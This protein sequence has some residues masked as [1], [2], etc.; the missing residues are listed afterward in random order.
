MFLILNFYLLFL[1][2]LYFIFID[3][4]YYI[5]KHFGSNTVVLNLSSINI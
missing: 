2:L 5:L 3:L 4:S 1:V